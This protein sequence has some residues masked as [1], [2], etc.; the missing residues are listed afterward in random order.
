MPRSYLQLRFANDGDATGEL[1]AR[2]EAGGFAGE[3]SAYFNTDRIEKFASDIL[4]FPP[5]ELKRQEIASGFGD[6]DTLEREHLAIAVYPIDVRRGYVGV[7]VRLASKAWRDARPDSQGITRLEI[8]TTYE[9][10]SRFSRDL[11]A[12]VKGNIREALLE[13]QEER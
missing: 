12:L 7:R 6:E 2:A 11:V 4:A 9:P 13:G 5:S 3:S 10:L 8:V 1:F